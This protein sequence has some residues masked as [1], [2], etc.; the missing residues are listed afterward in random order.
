M[1]KGKLYLIK[2]EYKFYFFQINLNNYKVKRKL[3]KNYILLLDENSFCLFEKKNEISFS[4][5]S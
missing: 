5:I 2:K 1:D 4:D 3:Q